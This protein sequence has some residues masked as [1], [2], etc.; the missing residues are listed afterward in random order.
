MEIVN[1]EHPVLV[2][3]AKE[4]D[5]NY[6]EHID[7]LNNFIKKM[8]EVEDASG[9]ALPQMGHS[10]RGF[11]F[12][13][14]FDGPFILAINPKILKHSTD[15]RYSIE[16]CFSVYKIV[17][18]QRV[19]PNYWVKRSEEIE[20]KYQD[21][22]GKWIQEKSSGLEARVIQHENDHLDGKTIDEKTLPLKDRKNK[23]VISDG[24]NFKA[25]CKE[26]GQ[27]TRRLP[28]NK[29]EGFVDIPVQ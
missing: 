21:I 24:E 18:N 27:K 1:I 17:N 12:R 6:K 26:Y 15:E 22:Q 7:I 3:V 8:E 14:T 23:E 28:W 25:W 19:Y 20:W 16:G 4:V 5:L 11:V 13:K 29:V 2:K 10:L 9:M